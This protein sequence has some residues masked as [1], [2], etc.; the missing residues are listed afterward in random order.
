MH[1]ESPVL[2]NLM[3]LYSHDL[4]AAFSLEL[5]AD[6]RY[7]YERLP[8]YWSEPDRRFPFLVRCDRLLAG[9]ALV[10]RGSPLSDDPNVF[11]VAEFFVVRRY[12][13]R[14]IGRQAAVVLWNRF[15]ARWTVRVSEENRQGCEFWASV[16]T[17]YTNGEFLEARRSVGQRA[18]RV[19]E[20]DSA[21]KDEPRDA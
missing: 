19:F 1:R 6:G 5:R 8:L 20:L 17:E 16:V 10:T 18:W 15:A 21:P 14:G 2:S 12:R 9:F 4:S 13:R 11:D 3:E 7:G